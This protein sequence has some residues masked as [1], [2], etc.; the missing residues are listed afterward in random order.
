MERQNRRQF[1]KQLGLG[2]A[3]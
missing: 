1:L 3:A 2:G